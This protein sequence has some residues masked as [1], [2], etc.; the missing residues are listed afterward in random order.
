MTLPNLGKLTHTAGPILADRLRS[1]IVEIYDTG[2]D[3][4]LRSDAVDKIKDLKQLTKAELDTLADH[5][6][7]QGVKHLVYAFLEMHPEAISGLHRNA[8]HRWWSSEWVY[9][10]PVLNFEVDADGFV[11]ADLWHTRR[12]KGGMF[13]EF[14]PKRPVFFFGSYGLV[15]DNID[16]LEDY[17]EEAEDDEDPNLYVKRGR[18][19]FRPLLWFNDVDGRKLDPLKKAVIANLVN[20]HPIL[21]PD[22]DLLKK[23]PEIWNKMLYSSNKKHPFG[24]KEF[25]EVMPLRLD[26]NCVEDANV[27]LNAGFQGTL[28]VD[29]SG[30][31]G[32]VSPPGSA[33][34]ESESV[35]L[36]DV[37][38][39]VEEEGEWERLY[40]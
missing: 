28:S 10:N 35:V 36:W 5:I 19:R 37:P 39:A 1:A 8:T 27:P 30:V 22:F 20:D 15:R 7:R 12:G 23:G 31:A 4:I 2:D 11:V 32:A 6:N 16:S 40:L 9:P 18:F 13:K 33:T 24:E 14:E 26:N 3:D 21:P 38:S 34:P 17:V 25:E 29:V